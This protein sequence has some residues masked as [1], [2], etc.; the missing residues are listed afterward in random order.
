MLCT[1]GF[2]NKKHLKNVGPIRH[3]EP[4]HAHSP[5]VASGTV[6]RRLRI[7]VLN[8]DNDNAWQGTAMAPWNVF[9]GPYVVFWIFISAAETTLSIPTRLWSTVK[10]SGLHIGDQVG[11]LRLPRWTCFCDVCLS[12]TVRCQRRRCLTSQTCLLAVRQ[13]ISVKH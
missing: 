10:I 2:V 13:Q 7:D 12:R 11:Y 3:C 9:S 8:D 5:D 1:S 6:A 4:P